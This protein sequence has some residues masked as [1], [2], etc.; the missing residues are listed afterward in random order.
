VLADARCAGDD[1][2]QVPGKKKENQPL[3]NEDDPYLAHAGAILVDVS[4]SHAI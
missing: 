4:K 1:L 2:L 3:D